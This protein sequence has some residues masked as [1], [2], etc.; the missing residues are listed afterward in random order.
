MTFRSRLAILAA[1]TAVAVSSLTMAASPAFAHEE[2]QLPTICGDS[3]YFIVN[4]GGGINGKAKRELDDSSGR[5]YGYV[6]LL[7]SNSTKKNCVVT[8]K[9]VDHGTP[10][11]TLARLMVQDEGQVEDPPAG[12]NTKYSH[13]ADVQRAA[14]GRCVAYWGYVEDRHGDGGGGGRISWGN[15]GG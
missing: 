5:V 13:Y 15:C 11:D 6:Y 4:D 10:T 8:R 2:N 14:N 3:S 7:Y 1:A 9:T 12:S